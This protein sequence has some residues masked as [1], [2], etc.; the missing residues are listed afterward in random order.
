SLTACAAASSSHPGCW[1]GAV[2]VARRIASRAV[3][4]CFQSRCP[5]RRASHSH[6]QPLLARRERHY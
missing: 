6:C 4:P 5:R 3:G 1:R 2:S